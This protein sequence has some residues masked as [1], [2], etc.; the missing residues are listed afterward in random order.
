VIQTP[1][2]VV[3][4]PTS[5]PMPV[6]SPTLAPSPTPSR[7]QLTAHSV[8]PTA[9]KPGD[10]LTF[11]YQLSNAN[12][13]PVEASLG[14]TLRPSDGG[15]DVN[16]SANDRSITIQPGQST[17]RRS[18]RVPSDTPDGSYDVLWGVIGP[19]KESYALETQPGAVE[20]QAPVA[21]LQPET[22]ALDAINAANRV[23]A[24]VVARNGAPVS[25]LERVYGGKWLQTVRDEVVAMRAKGQYRV[26]RQTA[27]TSLRSATATATGIEAFASEQWDDRTYASDG[28]LVRAAPGHV[29]QRYVLQR[30][31]DHWIVVDSQLQ[32]SF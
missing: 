29:E 20:V 7:P 26:A 6:L 24:S 28:T 19:N 23:W 17:Y 2:S 11:T 15:A 9:V 3:V 27:A 18:F 14:A 30:A 10:T 21:Q 13:V 22:I 16:D 5:V 32:R 1:T 4:T 8:D 31:G 12:T 25:D